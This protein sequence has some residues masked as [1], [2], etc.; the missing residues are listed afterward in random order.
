MNSVFDNT[1]AWKIARALRFIDDVWNQ[2][3]LA[4]LDDYL[5]TNYVDHAYQ[6]ANQAGLVNMLSELKRAFPDAVQTVE[7]TTAQDD[8]VVFRMVLRATHRGPFRQIDATGNSV[9]VNVYRSFRFARDKIV[10]HWALLDTA[11]L[12][13]QIG[14]GVSATNACAVA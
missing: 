10:E 2:Q 13:R 8:I 3:N 14:S 1:A 11:T 6:P 9:C 12:L 5:S 4:N 7:C